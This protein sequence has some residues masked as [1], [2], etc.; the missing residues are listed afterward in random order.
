VILRVSMTKQFRQ[1]HC[2][3]QR[4]VEVS[5]PQSPTRVTHQFTITEGP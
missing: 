3:F 1:A 4:S 5:N 2:P